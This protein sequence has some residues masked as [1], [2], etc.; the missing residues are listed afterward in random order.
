MKPSKTVTASKPAR[1]KTRAAATPPRAVR[2][3]MKAEVVDVTEKKNPMIKAP[4]DAPELSK[5]DLIERLVRDTGM[6]K[7]DA[8]RSLD[9][10]L[11][12]LNGAISEGYNLSAAPLGK[13]KITRSKET[14]NGKLAV[15][16]VKLKKPETFLPDTATIA[17]AAE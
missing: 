2:K 5:K 4:D 6:K 14:A 10:V 11:S 13:V 17:D 8:R 3:T 9:A 1:S 7:G 15:C 12:V 16:R